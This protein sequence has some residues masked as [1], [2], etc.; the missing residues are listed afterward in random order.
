MRLRLMLV[1]W[2]A[3]QQGVPLGA[4]AGGFLDPYAYGAARFSAHVVLIAGG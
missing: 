4:F 2:R 3:D 1:S